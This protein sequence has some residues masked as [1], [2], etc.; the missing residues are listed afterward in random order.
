[1]FI[2]RY[3]KIGL[4]NAKVTL[5]GSIE[6][7]INAINTVIADGQTTVEEKEM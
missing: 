7:L 1:M 2:Y 3:A 4:L 6:N 5:M